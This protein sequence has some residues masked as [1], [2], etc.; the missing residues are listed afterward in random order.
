MTEVNFEETVVT[1]NLYTTETHQ[2]KIKADTLTKMKEGDNFLA[3]I[4]SKIQKGMKQVAD[5]STGKEWENSYTAIY[6]EITGQT[7]IGGK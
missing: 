1:T 6:K 5:K 4:A 2:F 3:K 7:T